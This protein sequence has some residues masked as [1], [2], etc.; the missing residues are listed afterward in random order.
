MKKLFFAVIALSA[1]T[2][3]A[4][5]GNAEATSGDAQSAD[6][7]ATVMTDQL[8][9]ALS[10]SASFAAA[11]DDV[12]TQIEKLQSEGATEETINAYKS[13]LVEF[14]EKNKAKVEEFKV[15]VPSTLNSLVE[16]IV[17][18]P[19]AVK[20]GAET[21]ADQAT[22]AAKADAAAAEQALKDEAN[23]QVEK[24]KEDANKK[25]SDAVDKA[26]QDLKNKIK[27]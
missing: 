13:K 8:N 22:E 27:F 15:K 21:A 19:E 5:N 17:A 20:E 3:A 12:N 25:A 26:A 11:M 7:L 14:Y 9:A 23:A 2:F 18:L 24:A 16:G 4:C 1:V 6:S 10:D